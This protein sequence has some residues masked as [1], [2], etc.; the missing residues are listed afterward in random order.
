ML[1]RQIIIRALTRLKDEKKR[2]NALAKL[3]VQLYDN[4][5]EDSCLDLIAMHINPILPDGLMDILISWLCEEPKDG[6]KIKLIGKWVNVDDAGEFYDMIVKIF[7]P[8]QATQ[9][10]SGDGC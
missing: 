5:V 8:S 3:G 9:K 4:W 1:Q 6:R 2:Q 10:E 7:G